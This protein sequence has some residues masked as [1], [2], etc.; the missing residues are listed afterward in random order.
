MSSAL[1]DLF[2]SNTPL[3][4]STQIGKSKPTGSV[5]KGTT[6]SAMPVRYPTIA[7]HEGSIRLRMIT[8]E[9]VKMKTA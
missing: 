2:T 7:S 8:V 4:M 9:M 5:T 1:A 3:T 6:K